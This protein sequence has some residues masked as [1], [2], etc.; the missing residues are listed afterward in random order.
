LAAVDV[1]LDDQDLAELEGAS[2]L[3]DPVAGARD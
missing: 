2:Q 3:R 1:E